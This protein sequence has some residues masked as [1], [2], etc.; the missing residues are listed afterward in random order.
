M[1]RAGTDAIGS[2]FLRCA[3][4]GKNREKVY[5]R[6]FCLQGGICR[7]TSKNRCRKGFLSL[8]QGGVYQIVD[9]SGQLANFPV[10]VLIHGL[11][12]SQQAFR[13]GQ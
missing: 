3:G 1:I 10:G 7:K 5:G 11:D 9:G 8:L 4:A 12:V 13:R 2:G 6:S